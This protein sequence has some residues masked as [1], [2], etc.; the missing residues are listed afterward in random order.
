MNPEPTL[1]PAPPPTLGERLRAL[2]RPLLAG[3][4][5]VACL[6]PLSSIVGLSDVLGKPATPLI[7]T[8]LITL[9]WIVVLTRRRVRE[10]L[11]TGVAAGV[12]YALAT[13]ILSAVL[14]PILTGEL[15]GPLAQPIA[16]VPIFLFNAGWGAVCGVCALG[17]R[18]LRRG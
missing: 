13:V 14:S 5:L 15:Q 1:H 2:D 8:G 4:V 18:K 16:I 17:L 7:L 10:P 3:L 6:R 12:G 11:L 9:T